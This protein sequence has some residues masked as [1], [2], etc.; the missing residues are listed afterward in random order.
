[1]KIV[2]DAGH[3]GHDSGAVGHGLQ[4]KNLTLAIA[5]KTRDYLNQHFQGHTIKMTRDSD[6]FLTLA[7]RSK[8][9]N[10]FKADV[11]VSIHINAHTTA[12]ANGFETF[13]WN[14]GVPARTKSF[15][16]VLHK[17][18]QTLAKFGSDRG[19]KQ[20]NF[21][22]LRLTNT[23]AVLT[24]LGFISNSSDASK[25]KQDSFLNTLARGHAEGIAE[26]LGLQK[27]TTQP[28]ASQ[29]PE[30]TGN[31]FRVQVGAY[32]SRQNAENMVKEL[33]SKGFPAIIV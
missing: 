27:K 25:L 28:P 20:A 16:N 33:R 1:M 22:V 11:F 3:G 29:Q 6:T 12:T 10:D 30:Q 21:S 9:S 31:L 24:E 26:F 5:R 14:G 17:R 18:I 13:V 2:L 23:S 4:E 32:A 19:Q 7:E 8:I 15:Q